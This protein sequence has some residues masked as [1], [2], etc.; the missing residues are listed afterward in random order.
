VG[1]RPRG[2]LASSPRGQE[3]EYMELVSE[4]AYVALDAIVDD[5]VYNTTPCYRR[6]SLPSMLF[7]LLSF[8]CR[9][10]SSWCSS[11]IFFI[12]RLVCFFFQ[13]EDGI[14]DYVR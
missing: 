5:V 8:M 11:D 4:D 2:R 1:R 12:L 6:L 9:T 10:V 13:A 3:P 14:R 7:V